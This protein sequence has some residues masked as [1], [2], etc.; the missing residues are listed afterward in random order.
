MEQNNVLFRVTL[1]DGDKTVEREYNIDSLA[2]PVFSSKKK[3]LDFVFNVILDQNVVVDD[4]FVA[5]CDARRK[6]K[7]H[8][9]YVSLD[10]LAD[11]NELKRS[12]KAKKRALLWIK[13]C[14]DDS[15]DEPVFKEK[16][17][18]DESL[19]KKSSKDESMKK[20]SSK[21]KS[22]KDDPG[23][24]V[25]D[26][27]DEFDDPPI[28]DPDVEFGSF[29]QS[30][31]TKT[32]NAS[33]TVPPSNT[34]PESNT[35]D[36]LDQ[37]KDTI[38]EFQNSGLWFGI[39][40]IAA[41]AA[42]NHLERKNMRVQHLAEALNGNAAAISHILN[43][44]AATLATAI[45]LN[46]NQFAEALNRSCNPIPE[47]PQSQGGPLQNGQHAPF[48]QLA[49]S[50][51]SLKGPDPVSQTEAAGNSSNIQDTVHVNVTCDTCYP[52]SEGLPI[53]GVRY[54]CLVCRNFDMCSKCYNSKQYLDHS[55]KHLMLAMRRPH[56][57]STNYH[58]HKT[59]TTGK[60]PL[61]SMISEFASF[62]KSSLLLNELG[63]LGPRDFFD[64]CS[65]L[66]LKDQQSKSV[67]HFKCD[68]NSAKNAQ[69]DKTYAIR[70]PECETQKSDTKASPENTRRSK[71]T[72]FPSAHIIENSSK[73]LAGHPIEFVLYPTGPK[74]AIMRITNKGHSTILCQPFIVEFKN[75]LGKSLT[76]V[77]LN[78]KRGIK[79][80][81]TA[82][83][84]IAINNAHF[85][86]PLAVYLT[87]E[88]GKAWVEMKGNLVG[89]VT[90]QKE[91]E[92][93][94]P[95][96][97]VE[98]DIDISE[99]HEN[100]N[101]SEIVTNADETSTDE[102]EMADEASIH[103]LQDTIEFSTSKKVST[104]SESITALDSSKQS[105]PVEPLIRSL[106]FPKLSASVEKLALSVEGSL[107]FESQSSITNPGVDDSSLSGVVADADNCTLEDD[108][109]ETEA[110]DLVSIS[111]T[112]ESYA[113]DFGSDYEILSP[114]MSRES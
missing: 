35:M 30:A 2:V 24:K 70:K 15:V 29:S 68:N 98:E 53:I 32:E 50:M 17:S 100:E 113:C 96:V 60:Q 87:C 64:Y 114:V 52:D 107:Y 57:G 49:P 28:E 22:L 83:F 89:K 55:Q 37:L 40:N 26:S 23:M 80:N 67:Q 7:R 106:V 16:S 48:M 45:N 108:G 42:A 59:G 8:R 75:F 99:E 92:H 81:R 41:A 43:G 21:D 76:V 54:K 3:L 90:L 101:S 9:K 34:V 109:A 105:T 78:S 77:E 71:F 73:Q 38:N 27:P 1:V 46:A 20:K 102:V 47:S 5:Q 112:S 33:T 12:L 39:R 79:P 62:G 85:K 93:P 94:A 36:P 86:H 4:D 97:I 61:A 18:K 11:L 56:C 110:F 10:S 19:K 103:E 66:I 25:A 111:D 6:S 84:N 95:E 51:P 72:T 65:D 44:T 58:I 104:D 31:D 14:G 88:N 74:L 91:E 63:K 69:D 82:T 13:S